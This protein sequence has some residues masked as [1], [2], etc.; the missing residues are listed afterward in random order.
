M[1][2]DFLL[3]NLVNNSIR[4]IVDFKECKHRNMGEF[5]GHVTSIRM[6]VQTETQG[7]KLVYQVCCPGRG[8]AMRDIAIDIEE[9][10]LGI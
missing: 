5:R 8:V 2:E 1:N 9:V 7:F 6:A 3:H 10:I 4:L